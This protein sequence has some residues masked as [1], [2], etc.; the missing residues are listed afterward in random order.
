MPAAVLV[1]AGPLVA[2]VDRADAH[3]AACVEALTNVH[4]PLRTAWPCVVEAVYLLASVR[5]GSD[6]ILGM[7]EDHA[8]EIA[9]LEPGDLARVR[10]LMAKYASLP[11]DFA[12]AALVRIAER[13]RCFHVFTLD[14]RHFSTYRLAGRRTLSLVPIEGALPSPRRRRKTR[15]PAPRRRV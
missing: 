2:I 5:G 13:D 1:D 12:D 6:A 4:A 15:R 7:I 9:A 8:V 14:T 10:E 11:M 3:H